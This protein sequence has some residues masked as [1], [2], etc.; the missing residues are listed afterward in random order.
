M[1]K[2]RGWGEFTVEATFH[3]VTGERA[4]FKY[5]LLF[6]DG[7]QEKLFETKV[8]LDESL[9]KIKDMPL[10]YQESFLRDLSDKLCALSEA[11]MRQVHCIVSESLESGDYFY[12]LSGAPSSQ[13][14]AV[15]KFN[16]NMLSPEAMGRLCQAANYDGEI[17]VLE[18]AAS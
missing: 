10:K 16:L 11:E 2:E 17:Q 15:L 7:P 4:K 3:F 14:T 8:L 9:L 1:V 5:P 6:E 12:K 13:K 18:S